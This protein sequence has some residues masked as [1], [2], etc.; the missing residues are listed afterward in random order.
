[1]DEYS[2]NN[3]ITL[4]RPNG[5]RE[6]ECFVLTE[7]VSGH[8][9]VHVWALS[10]AKGNSAIH[11]IRGRH[12]ADAH[13]DILVKVSCL[14]FPS[15]VIRMWV[16]GRQVHFTVTRIPKTRSGSLGYGS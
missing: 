14:M 13:C 15:K 16:H 7:E 2:D 9:T 4:F 10:D 12:T 3:L 8:V 5:T 6:Q 11:R 1:M